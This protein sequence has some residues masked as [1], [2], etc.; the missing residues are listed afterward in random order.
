M[1]KTENGRLAIAALKLAGIEVIED[2]N[3]T[4]T[5]FGSTQFAIASKSYNGWAKYFD[6]SGDWIKESVVNGEVINRSGIRQSI[7]EILEQFCLEYDF[8][9]GGTLEVYDVN[10][11]HR[12]P[13]WT[14]EP[15]PDDRSMSENAFTAFKELAR[16]GAPVW[17]FDSYS[18][19]FDPETLPAGTQF[20]MTCEPNL[21][22]V[23]ADHEDNCDSDF[24]E[25]DGL[26]SDV[27][28]IISASGLEHCPHTH[29]FEDSKF[30][31]KYLVAFSDPIATD[32]ERGVKRTNCVR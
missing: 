25:T 20:V 17:D 2:W 24:S 26:R 32:L 21:D 8:Y 18:S 29:Y 11:E 1:A 9:D 27:Y 23:F 28:E 5:E 16:I 19:T 7:V 31:P 12:T 3:D 6:M 10:E 14:V 13:P 15:R 22:M 4:V 30:R